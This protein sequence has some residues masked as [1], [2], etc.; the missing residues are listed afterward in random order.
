MRIDNSGANDHRVCPW[1]YYEK[2]VKED[3][4][5]E[6]IPTDKYTSLQ[7]GDRMHQILE[8]HYSGKQ[9]YPPSE[10]PELEDE[11]QL[12]IAAYRAHY[13]NEQFKVLDVER[14]FEVSL[15]DYC[16]TC[17][18]PLCH[19]W[20]QGDGICRGQVV[21]EECGTIYYSSRHTYVGKIDLFYEYKDELYIM[22]HKTEKR[23]AKSN[24]PQKWAAKDQATQYWWAA[25]QVY[26]RPIN[27]FIVNVLR[28]QSPAGRE[29]PQFPD[30]Q[31]VER[32]EI[33][34][35]TALRDLVYEADLIEKHKSIFG[36][37]P[38]PAHRENCYT[39]GECEFYRPHLYGW[40]EL[41]RKHRYQNR[42]PYLDLGGVPIIQ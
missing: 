4:G 16:P 1:L 15:P 28:R 11:A 39:W 37:K 14:T 31:R 3:T 32:T 13:P 35:E 2:Y 5:L 6:L 9:K 29:G 19:P 26:G 41:I 40:D 27:R 7:Y 18:S 20:I 10:V 21:C 17:Y 42:K 38:W 23:T 8:E 22:D 12:M 36:D 25:E 30:R 34:I 33:Q 24:L